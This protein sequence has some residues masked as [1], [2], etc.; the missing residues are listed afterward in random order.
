MPEDIVGAAVPG[1]TIG[2][3]EPGEASGSASHG[4]PFSYYCF[5]LLTGRFQAQLPFRGVTFGQQLNTAGTFS[6]TL[7]LQD[8]RVQATEP[9]PNTA[10]NRTFVMVDYLG[11]PLWGGIVLPRK[12]KVEGATSTTRLLEVSCSELWAYFQARVQATDYSS[13]PY[14]GITG[15][16]EMS[17]WKATPWD[18]SLIAAQVIADAIGYTDGLSQ[19]YG[20]LLGGL[21]LHLNGEEPS[22]SKPAAPP[23]DYVAV[24][25]PFTSCQMVDTIVSQLSQLGLGVGFDFGVD[26]A[27]SAGVPS[28]PLATINL[29][30]PRRGRTVAENGLA[31]D[32]TTARAYEFPEDGTQTANQVYEVGGSGAIEVSE[33]VIPLEQGYP[34][35]EKVISRANIQSANI[36]SVLAQ[37]GLS[38]LALLSYAPVTPTVTLGVDDPNLPLGSFVVGDDVL[39]MIP[40]YAPNGEAFDPRFPAGLTREFRIT[41]WSAAIEDQGDATVKLSLALPPLTQALIPAV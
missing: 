14:S 11:S 19:P 26:L 27:Y 34:L 5:D 22:G 29:S 2:E 20:N 4:N 36:E 13:P 3:L 41:G 18:A 9:L 23:G 39:L 17:Y 31:I 33:N 21:G 25:Y 24:N 6:G 38:D 15:E 7:D 10:P 12:W 37:T 40:Q 28:P 1:F 35:W 32:L 30:Y 16:G 8:P